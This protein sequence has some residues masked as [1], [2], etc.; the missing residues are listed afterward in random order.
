M[1]NAAAYLKPDPLNPDG[2][3]QGSPLPDTTTIHDGHDRWEDEMYLS[4]RRRTKVA[5]IVAGVGALIGVMGVQIGHVGVQV[6]QVLHQIVERQML[7]HGP[8][9]GK[10]NA[11]FNSRFNRHLRPPQ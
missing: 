8:A 4:M 10:G 2:Q 9:Q 6:R 7:C 11:G 1:Q 5:Y 3:Y